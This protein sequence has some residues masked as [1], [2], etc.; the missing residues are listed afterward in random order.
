LSELRRLNY[1][2]DLSEVF[3]S[4]LM[5]LNALKFRQHDSRRKIL[6]P[7]HDTPQCNTFVKEEEQALSRQTGGTG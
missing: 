2:Q 6:S 4:E 7:S 1:F 3:Y 5:Y